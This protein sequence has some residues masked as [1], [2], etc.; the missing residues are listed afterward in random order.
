MNLDPRTLDIVFLVANVSTAPAWL[1][2]VFAPTSQ[3]TRWLTQSVLPFALLSVAY[4]VLLFT[5]FGGGGDASMFS[6][7]GVM[8]IFDKPQTAI[9]A[10]IHYLVFD[11]F[12]GAWEAEDAKTHGIRRIVLIPCL[13]GTWFFGPAGFLVYLLARTVQRRS[14]WLDHSSC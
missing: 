14:V 3:I 9:A 10:W 12:V 1:A 8:A 7:N 11:L 4:C 13:F 5:D 6:L 2:L